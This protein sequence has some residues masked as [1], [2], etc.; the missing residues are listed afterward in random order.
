MDSNQYE[1]NPD[2]S[3][4]RMLQLFQRM[5]QLE[6][7]KIPNQGL[8]ITMAQMQLIRFVGENPGC[9]LQDVAE[10]LGLSSPTVSV[11]IRRLEEMNL[12]A[13]EPDPDDGRATCLTL[14]RKS[15]KAFNQV[16]KQMFERMKI[17]L[18]HLTGEEQNQL[19]KLMEKAV[20]GIEL[21][22]Q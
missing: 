2:G 11:S 3:V 10:G 22:A 16:T 13:R 8:E 14:T 6:L 15:M 9:H 5:Q 4:A 1:Q 20:S 21:S 19:I 17:F 18:S 7:G 12:I